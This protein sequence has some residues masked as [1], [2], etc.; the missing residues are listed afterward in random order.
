LAT[1]SWKTFFKLTGNKYASV[2]FLKINKNVVEKTYQQI[3]TDY[4]VAPN[5]AKT[6]YLEKTSLTTNKIKY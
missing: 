5:V 2:A 6:L 3:L 4:Q 1:P